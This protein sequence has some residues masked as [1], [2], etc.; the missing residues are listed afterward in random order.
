MQ[1]WF[2]SKREEQ[3]EHRVK[4]GGQDVCVPTPEFNAIQQMAHMYHHLFDGGVGFRQVL[5]YYFVLQN[6]DMEK[7]KDELISAIEHIGMKRF[8]SAMMWV[9][10]EVMGLEADRMIVA[11]NE[12]DGRFLLEEIM[13]GGN[14]G[15]YDD[16]QT[17][18]SSHYL[19]SFLGGV[20]WNL[21]FLRFNPFDWF[22]GPLWRIFYFCWRKAH[23]YH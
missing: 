14:F 18:D 16:K 11:P 4:V 22:W 8:A 12:E 17:R 7:S 9:L 10:H 13:R 5:D 1:K 21:R 23:G 15:K 2:D 20:T 6:L 3:F 19:S